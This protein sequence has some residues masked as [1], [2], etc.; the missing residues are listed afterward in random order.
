MLAAAA[1]LPQTP[2]PGARRANRGGRLLSVP[3]R[4]GRSSGLSVS[5]SKSGLCCTF[6]WA[7]RAPNGPKHNGFESVF[8]FIPLGGL[9]PPPACPPRDRLYGLLVL[10]NA[11]H[12]YAKHV[13][14]W[15][16]GTCHY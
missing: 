13:V 9:C 3:A 11:R 2:G 5:H 4:P 1:G 16:A 15:D 7:R 6:V 8:D 12:Y 14:S 10:Q